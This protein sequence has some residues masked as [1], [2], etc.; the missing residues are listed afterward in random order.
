M[1][2][3]K[4]PIHKEMGSLTFVSLGK[5]EYLLEETVEGWFSGREYVFNEIHSDL[6][7]LQ[8]VEQLLSQ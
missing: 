3:N 8:P 1:H 7:L 5:A 2:L 4:P 6:E